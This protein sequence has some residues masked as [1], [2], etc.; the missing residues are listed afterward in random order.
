MTGKDHIEKMLVLSTGHAP[1]SSPSFGPFR[2]LE[3][4]EYN[5]AL[6]VKSV[7]IDDSSEIPLWLL[8]IWIYALKNSCSIILFDRDA[9]QLDQFKLYDW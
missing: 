9:I 2:Y 7:S 4:E 3:D 5:W 8:P 6:F 1:S